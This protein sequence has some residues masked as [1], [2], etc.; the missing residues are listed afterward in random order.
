MRM[1]VILFLVFSTSVVAGDNLSKDKKVEAQ[2]F[3]WELVIDRG[4][5][6]GCIYD[7]KFYSDGSILIEET[8]PRKCKIDSNRDGYWAEL[9]ERELELF[10]ASVRAQ[11]K[12]EIESTHFGSIKIDKYEAAM[13]RLMRKSATR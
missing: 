6:N 7:N 9:D 12:L 2:G 5:I 1:I 3:P 11:Q 10:E 8:L 13:L 4:K